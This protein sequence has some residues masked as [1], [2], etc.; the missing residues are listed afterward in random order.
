MRALR[1]SGCGSPVV[2]HERSSAADF[3]ELAAYRRMGRARMTPIRDYPQI[4]KRTTERLD[5]SLDSASF[6]S[7]PEVTHRWISM[8]I[9]GVA[10]HDP[11]PHIVCCKSGWLSAVLHLAVLTL[12]QLLAV[13]ANRRW[14]ASR[15]ARAQ[16]DPAKLVRTRTLYSLPERPEADVAGLTNPTWEGLYLDVACRAVHHNCLGPPLCSTV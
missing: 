9:W 4:D 3:L 1:F 13:W 14:A 10:C 5:G 8:E 16:N 6:C 15:A 2:R 12:L 11:R 7:D